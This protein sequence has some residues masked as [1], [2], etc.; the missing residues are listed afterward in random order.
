MKSVLPP[1][2]E[3]KRL[4]IAKAH[5]WAVV[6]LLALIFAG[7]L[8]YAA[9]VP[10]NANHRPTRLGLFAGLLSVVLVEAYG[11]YRII[12]HDNE[13][14]RELGYMCPY[15]QKPLYEARASTWMTGL[16]PKCGK[17]VIP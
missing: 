17:S 5:N 7:F 10:R 9:F 14:C 13:M 16:C 6:C 4:R 2:L 8:L 11:L 15:C 12:R 3:S 1:E